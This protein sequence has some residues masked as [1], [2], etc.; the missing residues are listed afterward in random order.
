MHSKRHRKQRQLI[1]AFR[2]VSRNGRRTPNANTVTPAEAWR[3][4]IAWRIV[5]T[6]QEER[7]TQKIT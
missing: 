5:S 6:A 7:Q 2:F 3:N 4:H 1:A